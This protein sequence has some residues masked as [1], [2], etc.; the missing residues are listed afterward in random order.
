M[1]NDIIVIL[2]MAHEYVCEDCGSLLIHSN[3][4]TL[5][6]M[7]DVHSQLC[8]IKRQK[9]IASQSIKEISTSSNMQST[10][11]VSQ[12][13]NNA[14]TSNAPTISKPSSGETSISLTGNGT[15]YSKVDGPIDTGFKSKRQKQ[16]KFKGISVWGPY[17]APGQLGIWGDSV[18]VDFD[19]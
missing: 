6:S 5:E 12:I 1:I 17:D 13:P 9:Y 10:L 7:K 19:I 8:M 3:Q 11:Q 18:C 16:G 2:N 15:D 4:L 14:S